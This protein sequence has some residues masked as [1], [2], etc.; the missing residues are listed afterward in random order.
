MLLH[1]LHRLRDERPTF[2]AS[3]SVVTFPTNV[4]GGNSKQMPQRQGIS[5]NTLSSRNLHF[6]RGQ[7]CVRSYWERKDPFAESRNFW[8]L[9]PQCSSIFRGQASQQFRSKDKFISVLRKIQWYQDTCVKK[10]IRL[11]DNTQC[12]KCKKVWIWT[13]FRS[14]GRRYLES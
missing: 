3:G 4:Q 1:R 2:Y 8:I 6:A 13:R 14:L 9:V 12:R 5:Q 10:R 11:H 7:R